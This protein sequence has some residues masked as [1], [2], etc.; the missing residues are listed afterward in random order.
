MHHSE[1]SFHNVTRVEA[2]PPKRLFQSNGSPFST[3]R[4]TI[5]DADGLSDVVLYAADENALELL[6]HEPTEA[7]LKRLTTEELDA[8]ANAVR[9]ERQ[10]RDP[11]PAPD[12]QDYPSQEAYE[13]ALEMHEKFQAA[14]ILLA[15]DDTVPA[16]T[17]VAEHLAARYAEI[18]RHPRDCPGG[19][20]TVTEDDGE[21]PF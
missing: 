1:H 9:A 8:L 16:G 6:Y 12:A 3:R 4:I 5:H 17:S 7:G 21:V 2:P 10:S 11:Q 13:A 18:D 20:V 15:P 19:P 14:Q